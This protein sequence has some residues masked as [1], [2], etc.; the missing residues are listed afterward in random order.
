MTKKNLTTRKRM[1]QNAVLT[2]ISVYTVWCASWICSTACK[3]FCIPR[4]LYPALHDA[5]NKP[6]ESLCKALWGIA[7]IKNK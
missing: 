2:I 5:G 6:E 4:S 1:V 3:L 7:V